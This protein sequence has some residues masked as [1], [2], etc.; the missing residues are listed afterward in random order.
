MI[1]KKAKKAKAAKKNAGKRKGAARGKKTINSDEVR[2]NIAKMVGAHAQLMTAAVIGEGEKG[3]LAPV[4]YLFEMANIYPAPTE[5]A[6]SSA[7]EESLAETLLRT[8]NIPKPK[9]EGEPEEQGE[10]GIAARQAEDNS[11]HEDSE[12]VGEERKMAPEQ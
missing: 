3:Q 2:K 11:S 5:G 4:K 7:N 9:K 1:P 10:T 8:L 6:E 12:K